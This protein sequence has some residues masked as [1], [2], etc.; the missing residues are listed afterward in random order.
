M[1]SYS[2]PVVTFM[3]TNN[4]G[5]YTFAPSTWDV[6]EDGS[7]YIR[8]SL[9]TL[10]PSTVTST[11]TDVT[12]TTTYSIDYT[13]VTNVD[14]AVSGLSWV[15]VQGSHAVFSAVGFNDSWNGS[16][17]LSA[18]NDFVTA[19]TTTTTPI[20]PAPVTPPY[21]TTTTTTTSYTFSQTDLSNNLV[22][23]LDGDTTSPTLV[24]VKAV[25][26]APSGF[27]A[28]PP[29]AGDYYFHVTFSEAV[30]GGENRYSYLAP[31][32]FEVYNVFMP[33]AAADRDEFLVQ[34][35]AL[36]PG[37]NLPPPTTLQINDPLEATGGITAVTSLPSGF[38]TYSASGGGATGGWYK[39]ELSKTVPKELFFQTGSSTIVD[40]SLIQLTD[41]TS[42]TLPNPN[43]REIALPTTTTNVVYFRLNS[44]LTPAQLE[45]LSVDFS[46]NNTAYKSIVGPDQ[47]IRDD[48]WNDLTPNDVVN[49]TSGTLPSNGTAPPINPPTIGGFD[50]LRINLAADDVY[51]DATTEYLTRTYDLAGKQVTSS[52]EFTGSNFTRY[53][54]AADTVIFDGISAVSD[55][56]ALSRIG[57]NAIKLQSS[58][59]VGE[60]DIIDYSN[61]TVTSSN[62]A[63]ITINLGALSATGHPYVQVDFGPTNVLT[64]TDGASSGVNGATSN[65]TESSQL[66]FKALA[67]SESITVGGLTFTAGSGGATDSQVATAFSGIA[68][69]TAATSLSA[70]TAGGTFTAGT[71]SGW[72]AGTVDGS[73]VTFTSATA[74]ANV[75]DLKTNDLVSGAEGVV[76]TSGK[77]NITGDS[78]ANVLLGGAGVD[79]LKGQA[80]DDVLLGGDGYDDLQGGAGLDF[81]VDTEGGAVMR[82]GTELNRSVSST[83]PKDIFV[84]RTGSSIEDYHTTNSGAGLAGRAVGNINDVI[85]FN[86]TVGAMLQQIS[87]TYQ[88]LTLTS[89]DLAANAEEISGNIH[90]TYTWN[91]DDTSTAVVNDGY[92]QV[93][94]D[95]HFLRV[96]G[97]TDSRVN[98]DLGDVKV[99]AFS[100]N[101][102]TP[103]TGTGGV[104]LAAVRLHDSYFD[105]PAVGN[106]LSN[107][108]DQNVLNNLVPDFMDNLEGNSTD[109]NLAFALEAVRAGTVRAP[110]N[111][112]TLMFGDQLNGAIFNP[113]QASETIFGSR[114]TDNY[115]FLVQNFTPSASPSTIQS[116]GN[117]IIRDIG[118][119]DAVTFSG[120]SLANIADLT[121]TAVKVG[122]ENGKYSLKTNYSQAETGIAT[123]DGSF[124]W[125]GHFREGLD[126]GL[127]EIKLG[128]GATATSLKLATNV[129]N[130]NTLGNL[131]SETPI[132]QAMEGV[133]T[134]MVGGAGKSADRNIFKLKGDGITNTPTTT[135]LD[136]TDL[137]IWG[138]DQDNDVIDLKEYISV[139]APPVTALTND[140]KLADYKA[141]IGSK[142]DPS[143][144]ANKFSVNLD[145]NDADT[146]ELTIHFMGMGTTPV[147]EGTLEEMIARAYLS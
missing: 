2:T 92:W 42:T 11:V 69:N 137:Y 139:I 45:N 8:V 101:G 82:G 136:G 118:G 17:K 98:V 14:F 3:G 112:G 114:A 142:V 85:V 43:I 111:G 119:N 21:I 58:G 127:E 39:M 59:G 53:E 125:T 87:S 34:V 91:A 47:T 38:T 122:R 93:S 86:M 132:Q 29:A 141:Q 105:Q 83:T 81:L 50:T 5:T 68:N 134:I 13:K 74:N 126:M 108:F 66:A 62:F 57:G 10:K 72:S 80:G 103:V 16:I 30:M 61:L 77:D 78:R 36:V 109:F 104:E 129:F 143:G 12:T 27:T 99:K 37:D 52:Y 71:L 76:G 48:A 56:V 96:D 9:E 131:I 140:Q 147:S 51:V 7:S 130:Y 89:A 110:A 1:S 75:T 113:G 31:N 33:T 120:M 97:N 35:T 46:T 70:I 54:I 95:S 90:F 22:I 40:S 88:G 116:A 73:S 25:S 18:A 19:T 124:T 123:N 144:V 102:T 79:V 106:L 133:D 20:S 65:V 32:G 41:P 100:P 6:N 146:D 115:E 135:V 138:I 94:A 44:D 26:S 121:F 60:T 84:V 55:V 49:I 64:K 128:T 63:G 4:N 67:A 23:N 28:I 117:D 15:G 24:S 107:D 145:N